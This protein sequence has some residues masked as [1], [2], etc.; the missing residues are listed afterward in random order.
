MRR[1]RFQP[2]NTEVYSTA[3]SYYG[4]ASSLK[5]LYVRSS[6]SS[7]FDENSEISSSSVLLKFGLRRLQECCIKACDVS[8]G[9]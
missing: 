8:K 2:F 6:L 9:L 3:T 1:R 7:E 5:G 4:C